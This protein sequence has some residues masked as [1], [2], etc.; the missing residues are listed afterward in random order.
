MARYTEPTPEQVQLWKTWLAARPSNIRAVAERFDPWTLYRMKDTNQR[1]TVVSFAAGEKVTM[2]VNITG[3]FNMLTFDR[4]VFGV[5]PDNLEPCD[6]PLPDE[7]T[8]A[9][10]SDSEVVKNIDSLRVTIR[11]DL[12]EL[13]DN[14]LAVRKR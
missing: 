14:G 3:E 5:D 2:T 9:L 7:S 11:P 1:V 12:W 8:G 4:A 6:L 10:M 13:D